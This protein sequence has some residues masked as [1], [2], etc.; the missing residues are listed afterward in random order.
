MR[1]DQAA[2]VLSDRVVLCAHEEAVTL[3]AL[4]ALGVHAMAGCLLWT[5]SGFTKQ[6]VVS[7][8]VLK[9]IDSRSVY[10]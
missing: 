4:R 1:G 6:Q 8:M 7:I 5:R 2:V 10:E 9:I 3:L